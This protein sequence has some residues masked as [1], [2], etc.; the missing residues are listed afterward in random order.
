MHVRVDGFLKAEQLISTKLY[1]PN[2]P[3]NFI[4]RPRLLAKMSR[5]LQ[6]RLTTVTAPPGYGKT[7]LVGDWIRRLSCP[8]G[9]IS[10]DK[11]ENDLQRFWS[12]VIAACRGG[13]LG[14]GQKAL[15]LLQSPA[16][17]SV[18]QLIAIFVNDLAAV[19]E[20][21]V[22]V[23]DDY[24]LVEADE[25]HRSLRYF[26]ESLPVSIHVCIISRRTP[27]IPVA[28]LRAKG[29]LNE[30]GIGELKFSP[31]EI[32]SF[33]TGY[34]GESPSGEELGLIA[35]STEGWIASIQ[36]AALA[37][38]N[39]HGWALN[40]FNGNHRYLV[41]YLMEEVIEQLPEAVRYFLIR[42]S[43]LG[44][45]NADLCAAVTETD[46]AA[47]LLGHIEQA[48]LFVIPL[49]GERYWFRYHHLF[50][51]FLR[52]R[53]KQEAAD[54]IIRLHAK[55]SDW[56]DR[57]GCL[58]EA[59]D[60]ALLAGDFERAGDL[61]PECAVKLLKRREFATL[62]RWLRQLP[63]AVAEKPLPL[64]IHAWA[65][66]LTGKFERTKLN[67]AK[68]AKAQER[69]RDSGDKRLIAKVREDAIIF[70]N[71]S[72]LME[73]DFEG[74]Y[75]L[76]QRLNEREAHYILD[77][78][79]IM[80][81]FIEMNEGVVPLIGGLYGFCGRLGHTEAYHRLYG[82]FLAKNGMQDSSYSAYHLA[83]VCEL[84][85]E[86]ND[87]ERAAACATA[88]METAEKRGCLGAYVPATVTMARLKMAE[89]DVE[90]AIRIVRD[91]MGKLLGMGKDAS[92]WYGLLDAFLV[93]CLAAKGDAEGVDRWLSRRPL[94]EHTQIPVHEQFET[95]SRI[96]MLLWRGRYAEALGTTERLLRSSTAAGRTLGI[97]ES[98]LLLAICR[99]RERASVER[100]GLKE[101]HE[102]LMLG[103]QEQYL[104]TFADEGAL[105][106]PMLR[107][108]AELRRK[109]EMPENE[110]GVSLD[111]MKKVLS[112]A[113]EPGHE[114]DAP[115][116][117]MRA[118]V[119]TL[120][121]RETEVLR[122][123]SL[124]LSNK[125]IAAKLVL[126]EGTVKLH[127]HRIYA[128]LHAKGRVQALRAAK[129]AGIIR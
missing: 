23:L 67:L 42:T 54:E 52:S 105:L 75:E 110:E 113:G 107:S 83:A 61:L 38:Q 74:T 101:L 50:G 53:L 24:H 18:E 5:T 73:G 114:T 99:Y 128:K 46:A 82:E 108:Y 86:M 80:F 1:T 88:A 129:Q 4:A 36:L 16:A 7:T 26:L 119:H 62:Y 12:Y 81:G 35:S 89:A 3:P 37:R 90:S 8:S 124:G 122:Q 116:R 125:E 91:A 59:I 78:S 57:N 115:A 20:P 34:M 66:L 94:N 11:G 123:L 111:Y 33:W 45:M 106:L 44:R 103:E 64:L 15:S 2:N 65:D 77:E 56:F 68:L 43:V 118:G 71:M 21:M 96:R 9:W 98:K 95:L 47:E 126:T 49:D 102:A 31:D 28:M 19:Q 117:G 93:R 55:A 92:H 17:L 29:Q 13:G 14:V 6:C 40:Q 84:H 104:R 51:D 32:G 76:L 109:G 79:E 30:I 48:N 85:Y 112:A 58:E 120:T 27:P 25:I 41:D 22:L 39:G 87:L 97:V 72:A 60:H 127:L 10:L 100:D 63:S 69:L 121:E 70:A